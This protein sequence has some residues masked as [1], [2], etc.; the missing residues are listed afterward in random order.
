MVSVD[1]KHHVY[2]LTISLFARL[3]LVWLNLL[4]AELSA[5]RY[6]TAGTDVPGGAGRGRQSLALHCH[7]Q[8]DSCI[9]VGGDVSHL[10]VSLHVSAARVGE[11]KRNR[12]EVILR[13]S[14]SVS[15]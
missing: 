13:I 9:K 10:N 15:K 8:S 7:R 2:L 14:P 1:V 11:T 6:R 3:L 5:K 12:T 4:N